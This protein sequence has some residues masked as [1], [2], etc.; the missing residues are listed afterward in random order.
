[1]VSHFLLSCLQEFSE[2]IGVEYGQE[3]KLTSR[4]AN[5]LHNYSH[6]DLLKELVQ[7]AEVKTHL[8]ARQAPNSLCGMVADFAG[9]GRHR[10][11]STS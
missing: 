2:L 6:E 7:N 9:C 3:E 8:P 5:I 11:L 10:V 1:M 4:I